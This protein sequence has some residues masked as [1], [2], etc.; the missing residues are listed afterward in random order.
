MKSRLTLEL[1]VATRALIEDLRDRTDAGSMTEV[2]RRA[3][4]VFELASRPD[5]RIIVQDAEGRDVGEVWVA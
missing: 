4:D 2:I 5:A 3:V 1:P